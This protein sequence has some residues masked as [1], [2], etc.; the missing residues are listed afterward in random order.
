MSETPKIDLPERFTL[1]EKGTCVAFKWNGDNDALIAFL[2]RNDYPTYGVSYNPAPGGHSVSLSN[3]HPEGAIWSPGEWIVLAKFG[4][5]S[6]TLNGGKDEAF[7]KDW[8]R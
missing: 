3:W 5:Y 8:I 6:D 1:R 2:N 4:S 7:F